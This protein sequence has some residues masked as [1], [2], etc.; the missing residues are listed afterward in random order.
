MEWNA[1]ELLRGASRAL[2]KQRWIL[3]TSQRGTIERKAHSWEGREMSIFARVSVCNVFRVAKLLYAF[4][5]LHCMRVNIQSVHDVLAKFSWKMVSEPMKR[6]N[7]FRSLSSG[8]LGLTHLFIK[9]LVSRFFL[10]DQQRLFLRTVRQVTLDY[11][12]P[13]FIVTTH[14]VQQTRM[15]GLCFCFLRAPRS[16]D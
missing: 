8:G 16:R 2:S 3:V 13:D 5:Y 1:V 4:Q 14:H 11:C 12:I 9:Q 15:F 10:R 6:D 7:F